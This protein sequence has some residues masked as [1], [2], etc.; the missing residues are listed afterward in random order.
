MEGSEDF[1][2]NDQQ[3]AKGK[4]EKP[5]HIVRVI[6]IGDRAVGKSCL[7]QRYVNKR[8]TEN[9]LATLGVDQ[10]SKTSKIGDKLVKISIN[11]TAGAESFKALAS[12]Y[13]KKADVVLILY[14]V[15]EKSSLKSVSGWVD[16]VEQMAKKDVVKYLVGNKIDLQKQV[17]TK[18][19]QDVA[20]KHGFKLI[21]T[22]A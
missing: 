8:F 12:N 10:F 13:Y 7:I 14:D 9:S 20:A 5:D 19:A 1:P 16:S 22:S 3:K 18:E 17:E 11:D 4:K 6:L 2:A 21:E 15:T